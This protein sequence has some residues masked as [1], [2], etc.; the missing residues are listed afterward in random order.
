MNSSSVEYVFCC[1][2]QSIGV[3]IAIGCRTSPWWIMVM[4]VC[5][6]LSGVC[7]EIGC[8]TTPRW[9]MVM[10][11]CLKLSG[12]CI[13]IGCRTHVGWGMVMAVYVNRL[14][15]ALKLEA[16]K[17]HGGERSWASVSS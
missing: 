2:S 10:A 6:K 3:C 8:R 1:I 12:V 4:A 17:L 14:A 13:A 16:E 5:L 11:V 9:R 7:I 15:Y